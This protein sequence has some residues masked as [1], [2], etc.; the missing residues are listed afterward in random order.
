MANLDHLFVNLVVVSG[1][2]SAKYFINKIVLS[3]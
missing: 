3:Y 2:M 1:S